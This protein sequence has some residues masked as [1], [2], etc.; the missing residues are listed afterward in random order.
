MKVSEDSVP[1]VECGK[2]V[3]VSDFYDREIRMRSGWR[4]SYGQDSS[5]ETMVREHPVV[6]AC[7]EECD[8][9]GDPPSRWMQLG[10]CTVPGCCVPPARRTS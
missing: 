3:D 6:K 8:R 5:P 4:D 1:C 10:R 7:H 9:G 2:P